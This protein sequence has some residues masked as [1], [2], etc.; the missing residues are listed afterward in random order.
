MQDKGLV[1]AIHIAWRY[2][3]ISNANIRRCSG[4]NEGSPVTAKES[5]SSQNAALRDG[6]QY[7]VIKIF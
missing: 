5:T 2:N 3:G 4:A 6:M 1:S 7:C